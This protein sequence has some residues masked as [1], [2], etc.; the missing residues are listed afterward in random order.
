MVEDEYGDDSLASMLS[1]VDVELAVCAI[2]FSSRLFGVLSSRNLNL[3]GCSRA[4]LDGQHGRGRVTQPGMLRMA[5]L[6]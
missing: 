3:A 2:A 4:V 5:V 6:A 1:T